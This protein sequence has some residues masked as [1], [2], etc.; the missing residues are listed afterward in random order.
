MNRLHGRRRGIET[1][2]TSRRARTE[3]LQRHGIKVGWV[4]RRPSSARN[5]VPM[6]EDRFFSCNTPAER[7][8]RGGHFASNW[9]EMERRLLCRDDVVDIGVLE[10]VGLAV[11]VGD[12][13][14]EAKAAADYV[15]KAMAATAQSARLWK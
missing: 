7:L 10:K 5:S 14:A 6:I 4:S 2:F 12:G 11:A 9:S 15:T 3:F 1:L 8:R 13:V